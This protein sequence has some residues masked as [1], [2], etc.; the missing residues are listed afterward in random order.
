MTIAIK[1]FC[2]LGHTIFVYI[3]QIFKISVLVYIE[4]EITF[5][6]LILNTKLT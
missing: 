5:I 1:R 3:I 2:G 6:I 4:I